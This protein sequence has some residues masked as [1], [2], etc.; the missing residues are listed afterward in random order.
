MKLL[1]L[2]KPKSE[3]ARMI[4]DYL[5]DLGRQYPSV[6]IEVLDAESIEG[7]SK[8]AIYDI[9][10][11]PALVAVTEDGSVLNMWIGQMLPQKQEVIGYLQS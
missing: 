7:V 3:Y 4:E 9:L 6:N 2:Y 5:T 10:D 8:S 1:V 11:F